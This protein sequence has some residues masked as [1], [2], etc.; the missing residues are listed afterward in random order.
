MSRSLLAFDTDRIKEYVFATDPLKE[1]RGA[2]RLLDTLNRKDMP[3]LAG[4][5]CYYAHGGSGLFVVPTSD[6]A[7]IV[8]RVKRAYAESTAGAATITG[9]AVPLPPDFDETRDD[10]RPLWRQLGYKLAAEKA[11]NAPMRCNASVA[12]GERSTAYRS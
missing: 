8:D 6:V 3:W 11:Y 10:V 7:A 4:G 1:I 2:S 9:A 5:T 12:M